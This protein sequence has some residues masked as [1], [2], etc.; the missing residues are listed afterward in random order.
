MTATWI[1]IAIP[2]HFKIH[3]FF[4]GVKNATHP[5]KK[6]IF[7]KKKMKALKAG[8]FLPVLLPLPL[9]FSTPTL[10]CNQT[11]H[12]LKRDHINSSTDAITFV[13]G[14]PAKSANAINILPFIALPHGSSCTTS[15]YA[16]SK[17]SGFFK[18][19]AV[20]IADQV[21][22]E[23]GVTSVF[24]LIQPIQKSDPDCYNALAAALCTLSFPNCGSD[25]TVHQLCQSTCE[26]II[27]ICRNFFI[28][29][30][31]L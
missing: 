29:S 26:N 18:A 13:S 6:L 31:L 16:G 1:S 21:A 10:P 5:L 2:Y 23:N 28:K 12:L 11:P 20:P 27:S 15:P 19:S 24:S 25:S 4:G 7:H 3:I 9:V 8:L 14:G 22:I 30:K 17:C